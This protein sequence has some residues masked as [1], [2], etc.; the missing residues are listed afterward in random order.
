VSIKES[1]VSFI[2]PTDKEN[3]VLESLSEYY[4]QYIEMSWSERRFL[5]SLVLRE[6]PKKVLELGVSAGGSDVVILNAL[7]DNPQAKLYSIDIMRNYYKEPEK[8]VGFVVDN[9]PKLKVRHKLYREGLA[10][11]FMDEIGG[12]IDCCF[13]DTA[14][15]NPGEI[16]DMVMVLP[17]IKDDCLIIFHDTSLHVLCCADEFHTNAIL[18]SVLKGEKILPADYSDLNVYDKIAKKSHKGFFPNIGAVKLDKNFKEQVWDLF[19][20]LIIP[21]AYY[22]SDEELLRV[23]KHIEKHYSKYLC[24]LF[25]NIIKCKKMKKEGRY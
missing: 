10:C 3:K 14:H 2:S 24:D 19:N 9:Y 21:W 12:G 18:M 23:K 25:D 6:K 13:I 8:P 5:N 22:P 17:Y 1:N 7:K 16:L 20:A 11:D 4:K 15:N